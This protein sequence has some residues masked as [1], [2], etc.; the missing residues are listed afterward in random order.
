MSSKHSEGQRDFA[1]LISEAEKA[2]ESVKE[3][4]LKEIAFERIL[5][6]L[7]GSSSEP[8]EI[9]VKNSKRIKRKSKTKST[10][11]APKTDGTLVWLRELVD[12]GFFKK[13]KSSKDIQDELDKRSHRLKATDLTLPLQTLCR[14]KLLRRDRISKKEGEKKLLHWYNW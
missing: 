10:N 8:P 14:E 4:R 7:L 9:E 5:N 11:T 6:H 13:P 12:E 3:P 2:V 1:S